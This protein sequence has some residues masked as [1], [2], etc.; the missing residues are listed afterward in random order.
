MAGK[1]FTK[2]FINMKPY[3]KWLRTIKWEELEC[4]FREYFLRRVGFD[5]NQGGVEDI[6][7][8]DSECE[9][10]I[11]EWSLDKDLS[12]H[13]WYA[14]GF[15]QGKNCDDEEGNMRMDNDLGLVGIGSVFSRKIL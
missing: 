13:L 14:K 5:S 2:G 12:V 3:P 6:L 8:E 9:Q 10:K 15:Y 7:S 11:F 1:Q 4:S